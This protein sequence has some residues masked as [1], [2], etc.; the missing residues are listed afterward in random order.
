MRSGIFIGTCVEGAVLN[1]PHRTR[2]GVETG[3]EKIST[4]YSPVVARVS[5]LRVRSS[6]NEGRA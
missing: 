5:G 6:S 4:R 3:G 2:Q 1:F